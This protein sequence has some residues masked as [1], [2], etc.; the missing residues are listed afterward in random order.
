MNIAFLKTLLHYD[1]LTGKFTRLKPCGS[2]PIGS[3]IGGLSSSGYWQISVNKKTYT[4]QRV[5]WAYVYGE[6][7][8]GAIDHINRIKT[9]NR[10]ENLRVVSYSLNAHNTPV[11]AT[12]NSGVKGVSL[13]SLRNGRR[14]N[15]AWVASIMVSGKRK[16]LGNFFTL[17]AAAK[18]R[19]DAEKELGVRA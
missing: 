3:P 5:A 14:P 13:R 11:R 15:K 2:K 18:A 1:P 8:L 16:H 19:A 6:L 10:I 9:D 17:E 4:A 12:N 7:P